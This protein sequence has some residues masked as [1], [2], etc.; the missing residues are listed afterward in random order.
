MK[1]VDASLRAALAIAALAVLTA[2]AARA[3]TPTRESPSF[4]STK[5]ETVIPAA[6]G[7]WRI[8]TSIVPVAP[9][10]SAL[11][12]IE[13]I[14]SETL[15]RTY[16]N[17]RGQRIMLSLAYGRRQNDSMRLH[18]PEGCY[19]GQ[20]FAVTKPVA[21][22]LEVGERQ[23]PVRRL[24]ATLAPRN[25][26]ITYWMVVGGTSALSQFQAKLAQL[27]FGMRGYVADGLLF[28][29]SSIGNDEAAGYRLQDAFVRDL[30]GAVDPS[31]RTGLLG[32]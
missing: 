19:S 31:Y 24:V 11:A 27:R 21:G 3:M 10:P 20:G 2:L 32:Q 4:P 29:V 30:I 16:V 25:E 26:P 28:R 13:S 23:L 15:A 14:Y 6:F 9:D 8:D 22:T 18:Q 5:L 7:E 1:R 12:L 17:G